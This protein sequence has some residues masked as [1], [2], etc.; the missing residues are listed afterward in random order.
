MK[1]IDKHVMHPIDCVL[2]DDRAMETFFEDDDPIADT[3]RE[4]HYNKNG[5]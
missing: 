2:L 3:S 5:V 1:R 4:K